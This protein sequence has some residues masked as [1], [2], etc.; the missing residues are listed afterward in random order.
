MISAAQSG[1]ASS[2]C[3]VMHDGFRRWFTGSEMYSWVLAGVCDG[4]GTVTGLILGVRW[5]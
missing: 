5:L 1:A 2:Q 3:I 4:G